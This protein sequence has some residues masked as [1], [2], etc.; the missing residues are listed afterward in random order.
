MNQTGFRLIKRKC[1][2]CGKEIRV[3][4]IYNTHYSDWEYIEMWIC[5]ECRERHL[6]DGVK[7]MQDG[8]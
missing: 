1:V 3:R 6:L 2:I 4:Q 8:V 5:E 7:N